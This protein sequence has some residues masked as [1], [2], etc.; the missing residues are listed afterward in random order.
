M[1]KLQQRSTFS[2]TN[3][4][5]KKRVTKAEMNERRRQSSTEGSV[6]ELLIQLWNVLMGLQNGPDV[7]VLERNKAGCKGYIHTN[8]LSS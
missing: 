4:T 1:R 7:C 5:K 6:E 3:R 2:C 8:I